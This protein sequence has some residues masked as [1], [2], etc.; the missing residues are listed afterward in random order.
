MTPKQSSENIYNLLGELANI[1]VERSAVFATQQD[2]DDSTDDLYD[3]PFQN[4]VGKYDYNITYYIFKIENG[5]AF[6]IE[7]ENYIV[8]EF[9]IS[10]LDN[11]CLLQIASKIE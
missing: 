2:I 3:C 8:T 9:K 11:D 10:E 1:I 5:I 7:L 6:G 4:V